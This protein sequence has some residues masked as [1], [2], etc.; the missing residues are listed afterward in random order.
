MEMLLHGRETA[1]QGIVDKTG[2]RRQTTS[3]DP[4]VMAGGT[5]RSWLPSGWAEEQLLRRRRRRGRREFVR[6]PL[7]GAGDKPRNDT[8]R[9][10]GGSSLLSACAEP[11]LSAFSKLA[12]CRY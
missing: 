6:V 10:S 11:A 5:R 7:T 8:S 2:P 1:P 9:R 3:L 12:R 4:R